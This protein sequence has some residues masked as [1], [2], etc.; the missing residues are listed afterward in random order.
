[1]E[2]QKL[3]WVLTWHLKE[4]DL[5]RILEGR[6]A[7]LASILLRKNSENMSIPLTA[8]CKLVLGHVVQ[9]LC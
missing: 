7:M 3:R 2:I 9:L 6:N 5:A 4:T 1:M 8:L